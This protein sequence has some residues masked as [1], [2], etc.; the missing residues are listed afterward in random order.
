MLGIRGKCVYLQ[1]TFNSLKIMKRILLGI[2]FTFCVL[3]TFG[4]TAS[5]HLK[6]KGIP[7]DGTLES[8]V[9]KLKKKGYKEYYRKEN[10]VVLEGEFAGYKGCLIAIGNSKD[11]DLVHKVIVNFPSCDNRNT[12]Y[13]MYVKIKNMLT[14]KHG[15]PAVEEE[16][17]KGMDPSDDFLKYTYTKQGYCNYYAE[18]YLGNGGKKISIDSWDNGIKVCLAYFDFANEVIYDKKMM[19]DL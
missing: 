4:Q 9:G 14:E 10:F 6:F 7:I 16:N 8:F 15:S 19:D 2:F 17:F 11:L 1:C 18:F 13:D 5:E 3:S 12:C